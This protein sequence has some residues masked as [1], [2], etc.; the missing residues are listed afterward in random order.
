[1]RN[2]TKKISCVLFDL[3]GVLVDACEWHFEALNRAL[4]E[5]SN[6]EI[7]RHDHETRFNGLPTK[8]K[9]QMLDLDQE[10]IDKIWP[11][12]QRYTIDVIKAYSKV[13]EE[14]IDLLRF[15]KN[16]NIKT[17][18][19]TNSIRETA[20]LMLETSGQINYLDLIVANE[21]VSKNKPHPDC[22]NY[23]INMLN[24]DPAETMCVEDSEKGIISARASRASYVWEVIGCVDVNLKNYMDFIK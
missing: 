14:K 24:S 3:D 22:Y 7:S 11:L 12:K 21:D 4:R 23:A 5:I 2:S 10:S 15:L 9:L 16:Q 18:C 17:A 1:M 6:I 13:R 20:V 8:V 19:V